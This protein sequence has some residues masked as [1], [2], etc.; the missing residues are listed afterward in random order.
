MSWPSS[1]LD[2]KFLCKHDVNALIFG[3]E[4]WLWVRDVKI[5]KFMHA[6]D[7]VAFARK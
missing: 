7:G 2:R 5:P 6:D 1:V 3:E 4:T